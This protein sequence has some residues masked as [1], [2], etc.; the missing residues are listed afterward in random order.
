MILFEPLP[1]RIWMIMITNKDCLLK[2]ENCRYHK[3][4]RILVNEKCISTIIIQTI[5]QTFTRKHFQ[6][7][8][9][10]KF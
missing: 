2:L 7:S 8:P 6:L 1:Y 4:K 3:M 10:N 9:N 5:M